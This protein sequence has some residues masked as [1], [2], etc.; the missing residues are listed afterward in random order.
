[1]RHDQT[2]YSGVMTSGFCRWLLEIP[3]W[4]ELSNLLI[5]GFLGLIKERS[6]ETLNIEV[7]GNSIRFLK[8][9]E[10]QNFN[11]GQRDPEGVKLEGFSRYGFNL[12]SVF[13]F[14]LV[15][16]ISFLMQYECMIPCHMSALYVPH[17]KKKGAKYRWHMCSRWQITLIHVVSSNE[18]ILRNHD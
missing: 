11:T 9:V 7:V 17:Q 10:T 18:T 13:K 12:E 2:N 14:P 4:A 6:G 3:V 5:S 15:F 1:M 16:K 8:R